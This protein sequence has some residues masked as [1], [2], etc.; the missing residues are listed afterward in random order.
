MAA[1]ATF[2]LIEATQKQYLNNFFND[3]I[4]KMAR[5]SHLTLT[6]SKGNGYK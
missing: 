2:S 6:L 1:H 3:W 4:S 5:N